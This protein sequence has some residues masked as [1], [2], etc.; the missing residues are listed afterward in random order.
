MHAKFQVPTMFYFY[1]GWKDGKKEERILSFHGYLAT[2]QVELS[3]IW[4]RAKVDK[5]QIT[6]DKLQIDSTRNSISKLSL[7]E[8]V[9]PRID[10]LPGKF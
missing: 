7:S 2:A 8:K 4:A 3:L 1:G 9:W 5:L 6:I 10:F